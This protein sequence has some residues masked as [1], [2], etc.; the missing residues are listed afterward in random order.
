MIALTKRQREVYDFIAEF[1]ARNG[2]CPSYEEIAS[3]IGV[4][5][6]AT[7]HKHLAGL[8]TRAVLRRHKNL[9]R[10]LELLPLDDGILCDSCR[11][12]LAAIRK[13]AA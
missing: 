3:G 8:E 11:A 2:Y 5:S 1:T 4:A 13:E 12:K 7:V 10:S 9:S 6:L